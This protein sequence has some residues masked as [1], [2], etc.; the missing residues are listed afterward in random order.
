MVT[1]VKEDEQY[2]MDGFR[3][4]NNQALSHFFDLHYKPLSYFATRLTQDAME[5]EDIVANCFVKLWKRHEDFQTVNN[6]KAFL[7]I[8]CRNAC[9]D[10][11]KQLKRKT[12]AQEEYFKQL[13]ESEETILFQIIEAEFLQL[14]NA[15][16]QLLPEKCGEIFK[17]IYFDG[18]KTDEIAAELD[19]SVKTIRNHKA[20]AVALLKT[21]FLKKGMKD[22]LYLA[23]LLF[24]QNR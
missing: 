13:E 3:N 17:L 6:I 1:D 19:L 10:H 9:L 5:A 14:L 8:S 15:E 21:S 23:L 4:G 20:R 22:G 2:W 18:K 11:L 16:I 12:T 7:Y 24:L